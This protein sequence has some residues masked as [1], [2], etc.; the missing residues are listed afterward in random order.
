[1]TTSIFAITKLAIKQCFRS[2]FVWLLLFFSILFLVGTIGRG[3]TPE[4]VRQISFCWLI[5]GILTIFTIGVLWMGCSSMASDIEEKRFVGTAVAPVSKI[6]VWL[7][8]WFGLVLSTALLLA[9]VF[10]VVGV[11]GI[12]SVGNGRPRDE[13]S[14]GMEE[15]SQ[16]INEIYEQLLD[17]ESRLSGGEFVQ[18]PEQKNDTLYKINNRVFPLPVSRNCRWDFSINGF[19]FKENETALIQVSFLSGIGTM[20]GFDGTLK[21]YGIQKS[22]SHE[23][24]KSENLSLIEEFTITNDDCGKLNFE[25]DA[26]RLTDMDKIRIEF[27]NASEENGGATVYVNYDDSVQ[28]FAPK[29]GYWLNLFYVYIMCLGLLSI[30]SAFGITTGMQYSFPV[31]IFTAFV[32]MLMMLIAS[33]VSPNEIQDGSTHSH[34]HKEAVSEPSSFNKMISVA[35]KNLSKAV[36]YTTSSFIQ[37]EPLKKIGANRYVS[38]IRVAR[39]SLVSFVILP[40]ILCIIG[41]IVLFKKEFK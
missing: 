30:V 35:A 38:G 13:L 22:R 21:V 32:V 34:N 23:I 9:L 12:F 28:V 18:T 39:W 41:S 36:H 2:Y 29:G 6:N 40:A 1:M 11:N 14:F 3:S 4:M 26:S 15:K 27:I 16:A 7:G 8:R 33:N 19:D 10:F 5:T 31:A 24:S 20:G 25:F 37:E 17:E